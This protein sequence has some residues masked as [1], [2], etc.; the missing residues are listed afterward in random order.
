MKKVEEMSQGEVKL[1]AGTIYGALSKLEKQGLTSKEAHEDHERRKSYL[2]TTLGR[3]V[4]KLEFER[5]EK[6]V[7]NSQKYIETLKRDL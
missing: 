6:L 2:L 7:Y 5:L 4:V 3:E 1:G